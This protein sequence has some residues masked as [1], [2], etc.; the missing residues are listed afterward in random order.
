MFTLNPSLLTVGK[1]DFLPLLH[2]AVGD[3][4]LRSLVEDKQIGAIGSRRALHRHCGSEDDGT[5]TVEQVF[6]LLP[7]E[8]VGTHEKH[9]QRHTSEEA[10]LAQPDSL[11]EEIDQ[12]QDDSEG[13]GYESCACPA[14]DT[15][16]A[17]KRTVPRDEEHLGLWHN[18]IEGL[19]TGNL[20]VE[21]D[22]TIA[23]REQ[24]GT[25]VVE[26]SLWNV[27]RAIAS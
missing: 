10:R 21:A 3:D 12:Q 13:E 24:Q 11:R 19:R 8:D 15:H 27:L 14:V 2:R 25:L 23:R 18:L 26:H 6:L 17:H 1:S 22:V 5:L 7:G 4:H 16:H 9:E 20:Q